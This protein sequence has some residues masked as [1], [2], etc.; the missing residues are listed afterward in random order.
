VKARRK[1]MHAALY[2]IGEDRKA[3]DMEKHDG[4]VANA[5][6]GALTAMIIYT[7]EY[8]PPITSM[9]WLQ[10]GWEEQKREGDRGCRCGE[11]GRQSCVRRLELNRKPAFSQQRIF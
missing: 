10:G 3:R 2:S 7:F 4:E 1:Y 11:T 8:H 5:G 9:Q 6:H